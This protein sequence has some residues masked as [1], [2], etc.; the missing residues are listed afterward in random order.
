MVALLHWII[1]WK[2]T[3]SAEWLSLIWIWIQTTRASLQY[4]IHFYF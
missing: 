4:L 1:L 2:N 3:S